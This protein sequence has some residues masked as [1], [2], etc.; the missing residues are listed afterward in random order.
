M[1]PYQH[2]EIISFTSQ[3]PHMIAVALM[4]S[5][6]EKYETGRYLVILFVN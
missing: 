3:L 1:S 5:D 4:N 6:N 2:D